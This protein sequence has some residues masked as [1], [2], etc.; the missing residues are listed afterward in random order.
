MNCREWEETI[1]LY[2]GGE[3]DRP[4]SVEMERHLAACAGCQIF[5]SGMRECLEEMRAAHHEAIP[6][7]HFTAVRTRVLASLRPCPWW[8]RRRMQI[9]ALAGLACC[10]WWLETVNL[11]IRRPVPPPQVALARP[12]APPM[13]L[14]VQAADA[15][16]VR[17]GRASRPRPRK[18]AATDEPLTVRIVTDDPNVVIYWITNPR[19]E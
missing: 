3:L 15:P 13:P 4:R 16:V 10:A 2:C 11:K 18:T 17:R 5:A 19:G 12:P 1:A 6:A 7:A 9:A 8:R 14:A